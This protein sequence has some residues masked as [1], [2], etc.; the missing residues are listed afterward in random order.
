MKLE[1]VIETIKNK[2]YE[3]WDVAYFSRKDDLL[4]LNYMGIMLADNSVGN[5]IRNARSDKHRLKRITDYFESDM[6]LI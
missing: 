3:G 1:D 2:G 4:G 5:Y 6:S